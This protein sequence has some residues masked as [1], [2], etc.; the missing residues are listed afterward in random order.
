MP[1]GNGLVVPGEI[2]VDIEHMPDPA[3]VGGTL[4]GL[5]NNRFKIVGGMSTRLAVAAQVY[6]SC[7]AA[8]KPEYI[9]R[10]FAEEAL[11]AADI[12]IAEEKRQREEKSNA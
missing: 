6:G 9:T 7:I 11:H 1:A 5:G 8:N 4:L 2:F 3:V 10:H 12:L